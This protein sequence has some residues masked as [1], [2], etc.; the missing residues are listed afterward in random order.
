MRS[1]K[2]SKK[3]IDVPVL[4]RACG[5]KDWRKFRHRSE[6]HDVNEKPRQLFAICETCGSEHIFDQGEWRRTSVVSS[7]KLTISFLKSGWVQTISDLPGTA[8]K[9]MDEQAEILSKILSI[10]TNRVEAY[11]QNQTSVVKLLHD[12]EMTRNHLAEF[13]AELKGL[14]SGIQ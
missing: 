12:L 6:G 1:S 2:T 8:R 13:L 10:C 9:S 11:R 7:E 5:N 4:C 3:V 14:H